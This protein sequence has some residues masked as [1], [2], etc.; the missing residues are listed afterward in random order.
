MQMDYLV[1][2]AAL[3]LKVR[4]PC[5]SGAARRSPLLLVPSVGPPLPRYAALHQQPCSTNCVLHPGSR[6]GRQRVRM[7]CWRRPSGQHLQTEKQHGED[8]L[9]HLPSPGSHF[10]TT[11]L[12]CQDRRCWP[13]V[14]GRKATL[15][16]GNSRPTHSCYRRNRSSGGGHHRFGLAP[17]REYQS[18]TRA[19]RN[20]TSSQEARQ[21]NLP[22]NAESVAGAVSPI[23]CGTAP[24]FANLHK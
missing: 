11:A 16:K 18:G 8:Y 15:H 12:P 10:Q 23:A 3:M 4:C 7:S 22:R 14:A 1:W 2:K 20:R 19:S 17:A 6:C 13:S 21:L 24:V 9:I 5:M